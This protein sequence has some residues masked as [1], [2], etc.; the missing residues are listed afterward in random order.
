MIAS[1]RGGLSAPGGQRLPQTIFAFISIEDASRALGGGK[2]APSAHRPA[3]LEQRVLQC[4]LRERGELPRLLKDTQVKDS[5][6][7]ADEHPEIRR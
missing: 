4:R 3:A 7:H 2:L 5:T 1:S 6:D